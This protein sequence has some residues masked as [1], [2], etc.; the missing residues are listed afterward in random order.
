MQ[1]LLQFSC[2]NSSIAY[3]KSSNGNVS[4]HIHSVPL[5]IPTLQNNI[6][7]ETACV[8]NENVGNEIEAMAKKRRTCKSFSFI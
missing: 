8:L 3:S 2:S 5:R 6:C 4:K 1:K 7:Q